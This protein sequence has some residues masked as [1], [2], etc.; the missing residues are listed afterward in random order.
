MSI[1]FVAH[2][3]PRYNKGGAEI[4]AYRLFKAFRDSAD[5][6]ESAFL[7]ACPD[8]SMLKPGC[9]VIGLGENQ[10]LLKRSSDALLHDTDVNLS[11]GPHGFLYKSLSHLNPKIIHIHH[12]VHI[13]FD[14]VY[15]LKRWF[16]A[17][18][19]IFTLHEYWGMCPYE[20][21]L[22][23]TRGHLC[24]GP[25]PDQCVT[26]LGEEHRAKLVVRRLRVQH[27]YSVFDQ[28]ISPSYFLKQRYV[29]WGLDPYKISVVENM[30]PPARKEIVAL[31][32]KKHNPSPLTFAYFGQVNPW[33]GLNLILKAFAIFVQICPDVRLEI[34]GCSIADLEEEC[35]PH[36]EFVAELKSLVKSIKP[37]HV[38]FRGLYEPED[39]DLRMAGV[40]VVVM[41]SSWYENAPMVI[42]EAFLHHCPVIAP[43]I[44]GMAEK[45]RHKVSGLLFNPGDEHALV[46]QLIFLANEPKFLEELQTNILNI[47]LQ[48]RGVFEQHQKIYRYQIAS[49]IKTA[50]P[51]DV[52]LSLVNPK[53]LQ[54]LACNFEPLGANCELGFLMGRLGIQ[55]SS[56][57]R[58]LFTPLAGLEL[59]LEDSL[60]G[61]FSDP[62]A[63]TDPLMAS[64]MVVDRRTGIFFHASELRAKLEALNG[65][66]FSRTDVFLDQKAK[67]LYLAEKFLASVVDP[68]TL[69]VFSDFHQELTEDA[70]QRIHSG[71]QK[72]GKPLGSTL[73]FVRAASDSKEDNVVQNLGNGIQLASIK[74]LAPG[75]H[76][77]RID[78][79]SWLAIL[80]SSRS[81]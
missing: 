3:H 28:F 43:N 14:L 17:A 5:W 67:Y 58:W 16:P 76:A 7:A 19:L 42:Q 63:V 22:L 25:Q 70:M 54:D 30:L 9:Q 11:N 81:F 34:H 27:Y 69:H 41:A 38:Y 4:A 21:R 8:N 32:E 52:N 26:C 46:S 35:S 12:Y 51:A 68:N 53:L 66:D 71:L 49:T 80:N 2:G 37:N 56:L 29:D 10:W 50:I 74:Q 15:A 44:G 13:G 64:D 79:L 24:S 61:F 20:G 75:D 36:P 62:V 45:V 33:K 77:D 73:L 72:M 57:F 60:E 6:Q 48:G 23:T 39:L 78:L 1:L 47:P 18:K 55:R 59:V 40:D 31:G 65:S